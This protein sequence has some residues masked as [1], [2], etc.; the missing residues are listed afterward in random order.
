MQEVLTELCQRLQLPVP[1]VRGREALLIEFAAAARRAG[2]KPLVLPA[3]TVA[4]L[5]A[6]GV[7]WPPAERSDDLYRVALLVG[8][9][10]GGDDDLALLAECFRTGDNEERRAVLR[11]LPFMP[12][13]ARFVALAVDACRTNVV[14]IFEAI[15]CENPFPARHF[16]DLHFHQMVLKAVFMGVRLPR[17]LGLAARVTPELA[18]MGDDYAAE[19]RAAGRSVPED[20]AL[21]TVSERRDRA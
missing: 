12:E 2:K 9:S 4:W 13:P 17:V 7:D 18:R 16:P 6:A 8:A 21:L 5:A 20:L 3:D 1:S 19:R 14:P 11:A 15:A 10:S